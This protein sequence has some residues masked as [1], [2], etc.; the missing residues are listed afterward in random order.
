MPHEVIDAAALLGAAGAL[1]AFRLHWRAR[2][3]PIAPRHECH[4]APLAEE[5][6]NGVPR[7]LFKCRSCGASY[8]RDQR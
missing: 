6:L 7:T 1:V 5:T 3:R 4:Y 8:W 2:A